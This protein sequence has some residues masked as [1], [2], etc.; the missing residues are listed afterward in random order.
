MN[1]RAARKIRKTIID[2]SNEVL[3]LLRKEYGKQTE[4]MGPRQ[5]YQRC[6]KLYY[7][8]KFKV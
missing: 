7:A 4:E 5:I 1:K 2:K 8:G 6:K 3:I